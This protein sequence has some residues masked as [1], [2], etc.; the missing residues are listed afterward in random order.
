M[1]YNPF[2]SE[3]S[4]DD[5]FTSLEERVFNQEIDNDKCEYKAIRLRSWQTQAL[6]LI[7]NDTGCNESDVT[8]ALYIEGS[9]VLRDQVGYDAVKDHISLADNIRTFL[10]KSNN[11]GTDP[12]SYSDDMVSLQSGD[13]FR[14]MGKCITNTT[15]KLPDSYYSEIKDTYEVE[16]AFGPWIHRSVITMGFQS[17]VLLEG[18]IIEKSEDVSDM[19]LA[20]FRDTRNDLESIIV[21]AVVENKNY[22]LEEGLY[23]HQ[24]DAMEE[25]ISLMHTGREDM[26][27]ML[28]DN[29]S[30]EAE[31]LVGEFDSD[32]DTTQGTL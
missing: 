23:K 19:V 32:S 21:D 2:S 26:M 16:A 15:A 18:A 22:W 4:V 3:D 25:F 5:G 9:E 24:L 28:V 29:L 12:T 30:E 1:S 6:R 17:S 31:I 8:H 10:S 11:F 14:G 20:E 27:R 13:P 7:K